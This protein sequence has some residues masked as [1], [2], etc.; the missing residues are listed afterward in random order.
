MKMSQREP[1]IHVT[2]GSMHCLA[3]IHAA[4]NLPPALRGASVAAA[5][6]RL[7]AEIAIL[8]VMQLSNTLD[9]DMTPTLAAKIIKGWLSRCVSR[10]LLSNKFG[11]PGRS[12][13]YKSADIALAEDLIKQYKEPVTKDI[14][15]AMQELNL[16]RL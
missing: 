11:I 16:V 6:K 1:R 2:Y 12:A 13:G 9:L 10:E 14:E 3:D 4:S 8:W 15:G 7:K 5:K